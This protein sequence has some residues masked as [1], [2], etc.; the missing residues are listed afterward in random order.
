MQQHGR[1]TGTSRARNRTRRGRVCWPGPP[2]PT[3]STHTP[4]LRPPNKHTFTLLLKRDASNREKEEKG[5]V[6]RRRANGGQFSLAA[7]ATRAWLKCVIHVFLRGRNHG[8][9]EQQADS[10]GDGGPGEEHGVQRARAEAVVQRLP[11]G[12]PH[13]QAKPGGVPAAL[14]QGP[15]AAPPPL[16]T[17]STP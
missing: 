17:T 7:A 6:G 8:K 14:R 1:Q 2:N 16:P 13:W 5:E 10:R 3:P 9:A 4:L 12:L 11:E 15:C